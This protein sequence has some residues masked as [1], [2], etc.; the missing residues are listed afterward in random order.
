MFNIIIF[1]ITKI[2]LFFFNFV[3]CFFFFGEMLKLKKKI[4][5]KLTIDIAM[6]VISDLQED[7]KQMFEWMILRIL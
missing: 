4:L 2:P 6:N 7:N 1:F 5:K 3:I